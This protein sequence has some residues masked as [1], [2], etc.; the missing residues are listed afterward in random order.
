MLG[1]WANRG[2]VRAE[3]RESFKASKARI[4]RISMAGVAERKLVE[5]PS[6]VADALRLMAPSTSKGAGPSLGSLQTPLER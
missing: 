3:Y 1:Y 4:A 5:L 6:L 2:L